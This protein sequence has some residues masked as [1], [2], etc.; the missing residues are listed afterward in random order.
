MTQAIADWLIQRLSATQP[1]RD[2]SGVLNF[3]EHKLFRKQDGQNHT[4]R[5]AALDRRGLVQL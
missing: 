1:W 2:V 3:L 5:I 4:D